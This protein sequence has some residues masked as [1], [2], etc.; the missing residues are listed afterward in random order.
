MPIALLQRLKPVH[1]RPIAYGVVY[2]TT[3]L[4]VFIP[5]GTKRRD[6]RLCGLLANYTLQQEVKI[7]T[8]VLVRYVPNS[9]FTVTADR[10]FDPPA[11]QVIAVS[12]PS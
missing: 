5:P 10:N 1:E 2:S 9:A 8:E 7:G 6:A 12:T 4:A 11:A 3:G